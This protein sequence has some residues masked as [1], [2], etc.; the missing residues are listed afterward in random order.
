[1]RL[2][3]WHKTADGKIEGPP[4]VTVDSSIPSLWASIV[5]KD[6]LERDP[7]WSR[8]IKYYPPVKLPWHFRLRRRI[9]WFIQD[10]RE[11]LALLIA[12][13]LRQDDRW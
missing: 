8:F 6:Q 10:D 5:L 11:R 13:W 1:M 2:F 4:D 12:P 3:I 7:Y 9:K